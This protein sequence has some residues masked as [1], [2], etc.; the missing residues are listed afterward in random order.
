MPKLNICEHKNLHENHPN[1]VKTLSNDEMVNF[2]ECN[3]KSYA[4]IMNDF[5]ICHKNG[6]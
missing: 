1:K 4:V 6:H 2:P 5:I 3:A